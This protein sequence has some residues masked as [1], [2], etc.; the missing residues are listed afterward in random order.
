MP[1]ISVARGLQ[2][3][4][5]PC[6]SIETNAEFAISAIAGPGS[7]I[8]VTHYF[9]NPR[10]INRSSCWSMLQVSSAQVGARAWSIFAAVST[11]WGIPYL[12]IKLGVDGGLTPATLA[13]G[14]VVLGAAVLLALAA[15]AGALYGVRGRWRWLA[16]YAVVEISI[17]F[18]LIAAGE[19]T[20]GLGAGIDRRARF[21]LHRG[22]I[23]PEGGADHRDRPGTRACD[24][25]RESSH[26]GGAR[27]DDPRRAAR[28]RGGR[29]TAAD[30]RRLVVV[31]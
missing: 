8:L 3:V 1:N 16:A 24:H 2:Y 11:L 10:L 5:D 18:P 13:W 30:P 7:S 20:V 15:R 12:F 27:R 23:R 14:R 21:A 31:D 29:R 17:P 25:V 22:R 28:R 4:I 6:S 26:R 19:D 9:I